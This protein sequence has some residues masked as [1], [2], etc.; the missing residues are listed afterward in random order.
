MP[1]RAILV[2]VLL[3]AGQP[4]AAAAD[5]AIGQRVGASA[6]AAER[7][8]GSLDGRWTLANAAGRSLYVLE[9]TDS[10]DGGAP[11]GAWRSADGRSGVIESLVRRDGRLLIR[12][13]AV[14]VSLV[15]QGASW[16]GVLR[17]GA[18]L[19]TVTLRR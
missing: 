17:H 10:P 18:A 8:A 16:R 2:L 19:R 4:A 13:G 11:Q 5:D 1:A 3:S 6:A 7:L 14:R 9:L 15:R 12:F